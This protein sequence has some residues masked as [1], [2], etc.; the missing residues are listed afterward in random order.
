MAG[1]P[2]AYSLPA[3]YPD[4]Y[5]D[6]PRKLEYLCELGFQW[7]TLHPT[8]AVHDDVS[9]QIDP[10][11][12]DVAIAVAAARSFGLQV[13]LE[14][15][16]DWF[17]TLNGGEYD[18][19]R[20]MY[21]RPDHAYLEEILSPLAALGPDELTIGSE[22]DVSAYEFADLWDD[23]AERMKLEG[24]AVGHKLNHDFRSSRRVIRREL[25]FER[26]ARGLAPRLPVGFGLR[27]S[28][29][30]RRLDYVAI[31]FYPPREWR[32]DPRYVIG[33]FGLG[34][35]DLS[36]PWYFDADT[37][38]TPEGLAIRRSWYLRFLEWLQTR[39]GRAACFWTAGHFDVLGVM[40]PEWRDDA[41]VDAVRE[42]NQ[43]SPYLRYS[44]PGSSSIS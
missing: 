14:P 11:G 34:S 4:A 22:L 17:T 19:R 13:R 8:Y 31:S 20:R 30:L 5:Q 32:L 12:P 23:V 39:S 28:Q 40:H 35:T 24:F 16:L 2:L 42:Y 10:S 44:Q 27:L 1:P 41:V 29:Y 37:F 26:E 21:I 6:V 33:E 7:V 15:H 36:Q 3:F 9:P 25:N 18:W 38:R 43:A